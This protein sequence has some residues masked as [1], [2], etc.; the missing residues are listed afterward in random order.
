[1]KSIF[2][3][4]V[5][6]PKNPIYKGI[7]SFCFLFNIAALGRWARNRIIAGIAGVG[8]RNGVMLH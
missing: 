3:N 1:M 6:H 5:I 2:I 4:I 8:Y 7:L